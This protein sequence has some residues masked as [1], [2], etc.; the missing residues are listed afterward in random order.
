MSASRARD[1]FVAVRSDLERHGIPVPK[2]E[3]Y[4]GEAF[5]GAFLDLLR[6]LA[7]WMSEAA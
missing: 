4:P 7:A 1:L 5:E 6:R 2:P 3:R